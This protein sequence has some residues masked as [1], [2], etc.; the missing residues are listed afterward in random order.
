MSYK[1]CE[2]KKSA[3]FV[4]QKKNHVDKWAEKKIHALKIL[5]PLPL[6]FLMV[7]P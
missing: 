4:H 1:I 3:K 6:S 2:K 7:H 5:N